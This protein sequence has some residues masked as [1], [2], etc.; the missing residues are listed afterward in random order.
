MRKRV[1]NLN[2]DNKI[3][4]LGNIS[5]M[6]AWYSSMDLLLFTSQAEGLPNALAEAQACGLPVVSMDAGGAKE[7]F[8]EGQ[9]GFCSLSNTKEEMIKLASFVI[10]NK[11]WREKAKNIAIEYANKTFQIDRMVNDTLKIYESK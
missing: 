10:E 11:E 8:I 1:E 3:E 9:S 7:T 5:N 2:L 6:P 4:F